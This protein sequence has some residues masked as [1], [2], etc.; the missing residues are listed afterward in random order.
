[1]SPPTRRVAALR[2]LGARS[3]TLGAFV[4]LGCI[5]ASACGGDG[6]TTGNPTDAGA[7]GDDSGHAGSSGKGGSASKGGDTAVGGDGQSGNGEGGGMSTPGGILQDPSDCTANQLHNGRFCAPCPPCNGP[8]EAGR[9]DKTTADGYCI[10]KTKR[11]YFYSVG[12]E[13]G[14]FACD[15]DGDGWVRESARL[16]LSATDDPVLQANARCDLRTVDRFVLRNEA[17][18]EKT[19]EVPPVDLY[20]S[21]RNDDDR[22]L[23]YRWQLLGLPNYGSD[24]SPVTASQ[25]N[26]LTKLCH[27]PSTDYN[28][29]G[30]P[31]VEE[32]A[33]HPKPPTLRDNQKVFIQF[34]YFAEL[35]TGSYRDP[36]QGENYGSYVIAERS[37]LGNAGPTEGVPITFG[38]SEGS[39]WR[40]CSLRADSA[41]GTTV[42]P[43]GM[44][45]ADQAPDASFSG[46]NYSSLFKCF[47]IVTTPDPTNPLT[48]TVPSLKSDYRLNRCRGQGLPNEQEANP[49]H[50]GIACKVVDSSTLHPGDVVWG[51]VR[52]I[53]Y[54]KDNEYVRG[55]INECA[56]P[57]S[58]CADIAAGVP[59]CIYKKDD[60]GH[61]LGCAELCDKV[62]NDGDGQIDNGTNGLNCPTGLPGVCAKGVTKC[63]NGV[64]SC[65]GI[66]PGAQIERCDEIDQDCDGDPAVGS[67]NP[68]PEVGQVCP[69]AEG[70][71]EASNSYKKLTGD[72]SYGTFQCG[73]D[74]ITKKHRL[75]CTSDLAN[76]V[77]LPCDNRDNNCDGKIDETFTPYEGDNKGQNILQCKDGLDNNCDGIIDPHVYSGLPEV[78]DS[79]AKQLANHTAEICDNGVDDNCD[80]DIDEHY[81]QV[82]T[83]VTGPACAYPC[84]VEGAQVCS[85][86]SH[87][88][89]ITRDDSNPLTNLPKP[90]LFYPP[91]YNDSWKVLSCTN[92]YWQIAKVCGLSDAS[93]GATP[94][95][96]VTNE[97]DIYCKENAAAK[98]AAC[99]QAGVNGF[100]GSCAYKSPTSTPVGCLQCSPNTNTNCPAL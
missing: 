16:P 74:Q 56:L 63:Q 69:G 27:T 26:P 57:T 29:N 67:L 58:G 3:L 62:D 28:D 5:A 45:F 9:A 71:D 79:F 23:Q 30:I 38:G 44:D 20:E 24:D 51:A 93:L 2:K 46:F 85:R 96:W 15:A 36:D 84:K 76:Q 92:G 59:G 50:G 98:T 34:S 88:E 55:C 22:L 81:T 97:N 75:I 95:S 70:F 53:D 33:Q 52:Y 73:V 68:I 13:I 14:T 8:G 47:S 11:D 80:G 54:D 87:P 89:P 77:E 31:D 60:F 6:G 72:C 41:A 21:D 25:I 39:Y 10:C 4:V 78:K 100:G 49:A 32:W 61:Q 7:A 40:L 90:W 82:G 35:A 19:V 83:A 94:Q 86:Y 65:N 42:P 12:A 48:V 18:E 99:Q 43:I 17:G 66:L 64:L 37:R 1:M 91:Y